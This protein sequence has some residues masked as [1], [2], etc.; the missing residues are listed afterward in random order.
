[1]ETCK[2]K[3]ETLCRG[4]GVDAKFPVFSCE[5]QREDYV[6]LVSLDWRLRCFL[7][8]CVSC[9]NRENIQV[10]EHIS[11]QITCRMLECSTRI[12]S[13]TTPGWPTLGF[14]LFL[15]IT[16]INICFL[17]PKWK[18]FH[19]CT[20]SAS[21]FRTFLICVL[22]PAGEQGCKR[23]EHRIEIPPRSWCLHL[24]C[25][26]SAFGH[27]WMFTFDILIYFVQQSSAPGFL[28]WTYPN[29]WTIR[30]PIEIA[31]LF[32]QFCTLYFF[33]LIRKNLYLLF[34]K[35]RRYLYALWHRRYVTSRRAPDETFGQEGVSTSD[36]HFIPCEAPP[37][38]VGSRKMWAT[39]IVISASVSFSQVPHLATQSSRCKHLLVK[40]LSRCFSRW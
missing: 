11:T 8:S 31:L 6:Q 28:V 12:R 17:S 15:C 32:L 33:L 21:V 25:T 36:A 10:P 24:H 9:P 13:G 30:S 27:L 22:E 7:I 18:D 34:G 29:S 1:M 19:V 4:G 2:D 40:W 35:S 20:A 16:L 5:N 39:L 37:E 3:I 38:E 26:L 14:R 23:Q